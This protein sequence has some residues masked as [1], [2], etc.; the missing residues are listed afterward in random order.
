MTKVTQ[1]PAEAARLVT[2]GNPVLLV[3][4]DAEAL[5]RFVASVVG[6]GGE[7]DQATTGAVAGESTDASVA[8]DAQ[9]CLL[10]VLVGD[11]AD[12][13]VAAAAAEMASELWP[14]AEGRVK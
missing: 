9:T 10:G 4:T 3:G 7:A 6:P 2:E 11:L 1:D 12:P 14:W 13:A 8:G 5:G